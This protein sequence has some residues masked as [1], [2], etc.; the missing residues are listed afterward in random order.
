MCLPKRVLLFN[1]AMVILDAAKD[2]NNAGVSGALDMRTIPSKRLGYF[3]ATPRSCELC[4]IHERRGMK[5]NEM[6]LK[7]MN[8]MNGYQKKG[9]DPYLP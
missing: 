9:S 4:G 1:E 3:S 8:E 5:R 2:V 7:E 6:R